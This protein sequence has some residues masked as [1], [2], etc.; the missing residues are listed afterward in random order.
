MKGAGAT[1]R[2][3]HARPSLGFPRFGTILMPILPR[4]LHLLLHSTIYRIRA[5]SVVR[6][7]DCRGTLI[8]VLT[9]VLY[10]QCGNRVQGESKTLMGK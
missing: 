9:F 7:V 3:T 4:R 5:R 10:C 1:S 8:T 2:V 6:L